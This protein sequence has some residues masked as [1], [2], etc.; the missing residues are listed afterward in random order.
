MKIDVIRKPSEKD[1]T[2]STFYFDGIEKG[3]GVED[4]EREVKVYGETRIPNGIY[5]MDLRYSPK[6]SK[7]YYRNNEGKIIHWRKRKTEALRKEYNTAHELIWVK[8]V[9][10]FKYILWHWG[11]TDD[12]THGCYIVGSFFATLGGQKGVGASRK[13]YEEVY[14]IVWKAIKEGNVSVEYKESGIDE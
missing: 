2:L 11:N 5:E 1:W 3:K 12:D 10:N 7:Q 4:E 9:P 13:K 8:D 14:P 6:F